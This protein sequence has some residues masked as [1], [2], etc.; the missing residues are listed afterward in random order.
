MVGGI[1]MLVLLLVGEVVCMVGAF[2]RKGEAGGALGIL[3]GLMFC[4][5]ATLVR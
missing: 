1:L 2:G 5:W 4:A 3:V